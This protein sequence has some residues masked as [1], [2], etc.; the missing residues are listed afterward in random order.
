MNGVN[1]EPAAKNAENG[2]SDA[3]I[4]NLDGLKKHKGK[5]LGGG[6][7][8]EVYAIDGFPDLAVKEIEIIDRDK[9]RTEFIKRELDTISKLSHPNIVKCHQVIEGDS[10]F[11]I[12][13]DRYDGDLQHFI[14]KYRKD[15][16]PIPRESILSIVRQLVDALVYVH[17]PYKVNENGDVLPGIVHRDLKPANILMSKDGKRIALTDFGLCKNT[18]HSGETFAGT[19]PYMAPE[20][21]IHQKTSR[22][23]DIWAL[24]VIIYE[25]VTLKLPS[26]SHH[27]KPKDAEKVFVPEWKPDLSA[28]EDDFTRTILEKIFVLSPDERPT[29]RDLRERVSPSISSTEMLR[30]RIASLEEMLDARLE[31]LESSLRAKTDEIGS[32]REALAN[33]STKISTLETTIAAQAAEMDDLKKELE[34]LKLINKHDEQA[35]RAGKALA[36]EAVDNSGVT[37]LMKAAMRNDVKAAWAR[38][39][40]QKDLRDNNG[41][42]ALMHAAESGST[43]VLRILLEHEKGIRDNQSHNALYWA[44]KSGHTEAAKI[45]IPHE[46]PTDENGVTALMR[47]AERG[48]VE[49]VKLLIP[50]QKEMRDKDGDTAFVHA[51]KSTHADIATVLRKHEAP[52]WTPLMC[53][54]FTGDIEIAKNHLSDKDKK[55]SD[56]ETA[57]MIAARAGRGDIMELLDPTDKAGVTALMRA[58]EEGDVEA[59]KAFIPL[60]KKREAVGR[61]FINGWSIH[62]GTALMRAVRSGR[63]EVV[64]L[65]V[66]HEGG[67]QESDEGKT[68]LM[69]A[70][71]NNH[72]E[73][74]R[75]L[76]EKESGMRDKDGRTA[77]TYAAENGH[78]K[79]VKLL[80]E[81]EAGMQDKNGMTALMYAAYSNKL[82]C[83]KLLA[84]KEK[85]IKTT[86]TWSGLPPGSTALDIAKRMNYTEIVSILSE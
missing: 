23:S 34:T 69:W 24:G 41:K 47:A 2:T 72:P 60:Q 36:L 64:K 54:A 39:T 55:N 71:Y 5:L 44:L 1:Y 78:L 20:V 9:K 11:Y 59:V 13:M 8:G 32:L 30:L 18:T 70:T 28:V 25:L 4:F 49:M 45:V 7:F 42:T 46:D 62:G 63:V 83:V 31:L 75:L 3:L 50:I 81:K 80:L 56:G 26:F 53:A 74:F 76:L 43:D 68:A 85:D 61:V 38:L 84:E 27:W 21:F 37:A 40:E 16:E 48:D 65:L 67:M 66:E 6:A 14:A 79:Y 15:N 10:F 73:C 19:P 82:D 22:A 77:L 57:L 52:S 86:R 58:A 29:A 51:L 33:N 35:S 12:V 17:A